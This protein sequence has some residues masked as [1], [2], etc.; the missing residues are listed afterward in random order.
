MTF[1]VLI[2]GVLAVSMVGGLMAAPAVASA[3]TRS[4]Q[5]KNKNNW[6]NAAYA[7]AGLGAL[8]VLNHNSTLTL[9]GVGGALYSANRYE[10]DR[11]SQSR[12]DR[13]RAQM[14]SRRSFTRNGHSYRRYTTTKHGRKY[15]Y[16]KRVS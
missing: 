1:K 12:T 13:E 3:Q 8:G 2:S 9:I 10:Q 4:H 16:F 6:R 5:Q 11:K 15:Y 14:F 7:S